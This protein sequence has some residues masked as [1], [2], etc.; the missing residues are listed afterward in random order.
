[1]IDFCEEQDFKRRNE[2]GDGH[3]ATLFEVVQLLRRHESLDAAP[4]HF[5]RLS[6]GQS[7]G[8]RRRN[9]P[10]SVASSFALIV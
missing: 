8:H 2:T 7:Q 6:E 3:D 4:L 5:G 1:M 10:A 9:A